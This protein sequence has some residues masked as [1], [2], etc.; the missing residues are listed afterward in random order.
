MPADVKSTETTTYNG[1]QYKVWRIY[2]PEKDKAGDLLALPGKYLVD[3]ST[4][5][6]EILSDPGINGR[7]T[8]HDGSTDKVSKYDAPKASLMALIIN[9]IM[10]GTLPWGLVI[11]GA[12]IA[13]VLQLAGVPAL[14]FS[15]GV[16]LPLSASMPIFIGGL[17]RMIVNRVKKTDPSE[18][19][20]SPAVL[21]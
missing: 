13:I 5:K 10:S 1:K 16:Y 4:G 20:S 15:V 12:F 11:I 6:A 9:G 8:S 19:D 2:V 14:A 17:I 18:S 3:P 21:L 7:L